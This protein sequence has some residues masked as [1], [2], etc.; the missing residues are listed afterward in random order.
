MSMSSVMLKDL[1]STSRNSA[2]SICAGWWQRHL[3]HSQH[4]LAVVDRVVHGKHVRDLV[5][6]DCDV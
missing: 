3:S 1:C 5:S 4:L 6:V 2:R